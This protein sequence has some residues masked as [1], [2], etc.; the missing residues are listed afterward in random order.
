[1]QNQ[2][3]NPY[4]QSLTLAQFLKAYLMAN[5]IEV[6]FKGETLLE[7]RVRKSLIKEVVRA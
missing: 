2:K 6:F 4:V 1:M 3:E 5:E 7:V